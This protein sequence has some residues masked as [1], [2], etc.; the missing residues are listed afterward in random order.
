MKR[1][2]LFLAN[3]LYSKAVKSDPSNP[4]AA[5]NYAAFLESKMGSHEEAVRRLLDISTIAGGGVSFTIAAYSCR[6]IFKQLFCVRQ[7]TRSPNIICV[8]N[9]TSKQINRKRSTMRRR[10][11][12]QS[13]LCH[14]GAR[15]RTKK[16]LRNE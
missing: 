10:K 9:D 12:P 14:R 16:M 15:R 4:I 3:E 1:G 6:T 7:T 11:I 5:F 8:A 2:K 13:R